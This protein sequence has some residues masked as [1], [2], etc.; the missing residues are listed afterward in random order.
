MASL[1]IGKINAPTPATRHIADIIGG[2][3][4]CS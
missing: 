1:A 3:I 2:T 4:R